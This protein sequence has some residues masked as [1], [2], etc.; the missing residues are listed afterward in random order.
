MRG[1]W[2]TTTVPSVLPALS[3]TDTGQGAAVLLLHGGAG[4]ASVA[5]FAELLA[6]AGLRVITPV[7]P[8]FS[9]TAFRDGTGDVAGLAALYATVLDELDLTDVTVVGSSLGGWIAAELAL[10]GSPRVG[11]LVLIDAIG[12]DVPDHPV[13]NVFELTPDEILALAFHDPDRFRLD[14]ATLP[15]EAQAAMAADGAAL[16]AYTGGA[17]TDP[18]LAGRLGAM[19]VPTLVLWGASDGIVDPDYGRAYAAAIPGA[20]FEVIPAA[21]HQPQLEAPEPT[22]RA[23][24]AAVAAG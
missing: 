2:V 9:G 10:L 4:L 21:G 3:Y 13:A 1:S 6:D 14:P 11:R 7:H 8:G 5:G 12:L 16:A 19:A 18:T 20:R 17:P 23:I 15:P 24:T 22:V